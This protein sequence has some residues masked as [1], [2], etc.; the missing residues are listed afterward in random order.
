[1]ESD[2]TK[3]SP[4]GLILRFTV[5]LFLG[6]MFQQFYSMADS[7]IVGK[8]ISATAL[9]A[10]GSVGTILFL[11]LGIEMGLATGFSVMT[12]QYFGAGDEQGVRYSVTNGI[13]MSVAVSVVLTAVS[14]L[15]MPTF[16]GWMNTPEDMYRDA[17]VYV[18]II[19]IGTAADMFYNLF[20]AYLRAIGNSVVPLFFLVF[21]A[22]VNIVLDLAF[23]LGL[24]AGVAGAAWATVISKAV[25][26][27]LCFGYIVAKVPS[28]RPQ[29]GDWRIVPA[30]CKKQ[31]YIGI[32]MSLEMGITASGTV[33][34]Q[35]AVNIYGSIAVAGYISAYKVIELF[36]EGLYSLG[37]TMA[38][39]AG[40]NYVAGKYR[41]IV[42]G[43]RDGM[44]L[45]VSYSI[46]A[47]VLGSLFLEDLMGLFFN[48]DVP[49]A[50]VFAWGR[51]THRIAALF[52]IPLGMIFIY[53]NT[54]QGCGF[55]VQAMGMGLF[56]LLARVV[57]ALI[58][59]A[60]KSFALAVG[61]DAAAW[62]CA[63]VLGW[64][65]YRVLI[66]K[67]VMAEVAPPKG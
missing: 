67:K 2:M 36:M 14:L 24:D 13:W 54:L 11:V 29:K 22:V 63:G 17:L 39:Y 23:I 4:F 6:N 21:S 9:A 47:L 8:Y 61:A 43:T 44:V 49:L 7:V 25:S 20:S 65:L 52:Y 16:L 46:L 50:E 56:E 26:A 59:I 64:I 58:S 15:L 41:R 18:D 40:Q 45:A 33:I 66:L 30:C 38:S 51:T 62:V 31:L 10:V 19:C 42:E 55:S 48:A 57:F 12:S 28:L 35:A 27:V 3:G 32:P 5:P 1:M 53:R 60:V 34:E 37:Q